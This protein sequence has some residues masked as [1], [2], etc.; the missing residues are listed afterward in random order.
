MTKSQERV[1]AFLFGVCFVVVLL[2]LAIVFP[3]PTPFQYTVFRIV[4]ALAA[5]GTAAMIPGF[6]TARVSTVIRAGGAL[7]VFVIVFF[8]SPAGLVKSEQEIE[9]DE[10]LVMS[11]P[12]MDV[13]IFNG[14]I[15]AAHAAPQS[16]RIDVLRVTDPDDLMEAGVLLKRYDRV[17]IN[18][19]RAVM[20]P[21]ATLVANDIEGTGAAAIVGKDFSVVA[22]RMSNM[23]V[24]GSGSLALNSSA[25]NVFL[26]VKQIH[27]SRLLAKGAD[28][29]PGK[30]GQAGVRGRD[31]A[32]GRDGRC[33]EF[34]YRGANRGEDG[35]NGTNGGDGTDGENGEPGG[36]ITLT[37]IVSPIA[38]QVDVSGGAGGKG[39]DGGAPGGF[40]RGGS[41]GRGCTGLGG[42]QSNQA[43]GRDGLP[44]E[45]GKDGNDGQAGASGEYRLIIVK[46]FD[47]V[48]SALAQHT[49]DQ[50]HSALRD[51]YRGGGT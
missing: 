46:R 35:G 23:T 50:L 5:A 49:N 41:G 38:S 32:N 22:R 51:L 24:D 26:Y 17:I 25:G 20:P 36:T 21:G 33:R 16:D 4:L 18:N 39:G 29:K 8:F 12:K 47:R 3:N 42:S 14:I 37:T 40:G 43:N 19:V 48:A 44:G 27:N 30:D 15:R 31:G 7:A 10:P 9:L 1:L 45:R 34:A 6:I 2:V 28:G 11:T 13:Q